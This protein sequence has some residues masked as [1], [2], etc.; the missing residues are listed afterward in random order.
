MII[1]D[2]DRLE[3]RFPDVHDEAYRAIDFKRTLRIPDDGCDYPL[4][5]ISA[6][7]RFATSTTTRSD[8]PEAGVNG[9]G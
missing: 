9:E 2:N 6:P 7:F 8:R 5:P 1:P 3:F 4:P